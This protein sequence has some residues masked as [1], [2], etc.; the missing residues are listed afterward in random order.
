MTVNLRQLRAFHFVVRER[1]FSRAAA[2]ARTSQPTISMQ[3]AA[4]ERDHGVKLLERRGR[5]IQPTPLGNALYAVTTR[6]FA[7]EDEAR[8]LLGAP[9]APGH[10]HLR[11][12]ADNAF[13]AMPIL[14]AM[15]R[16][17]PGFTFSLAIGNSADAL[18]RLTNDEA[19]VAVSAQ[20]IADPRFTVVQL[21]RDRLVLFVPQR[22]AWRRRDRVHLAEL[23]GQPIV[24]RERGSVTR[25]TF[26]AA[27]AAARVTPGP[28]IEVETREA[29]RE[30]VAA[31]F[32]IGVVFQSEFGRDPRFR[33][34]AVADAKLSVGEYA[35][36][37]A[38]RRALALVAAFMTAAG[39]R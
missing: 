3:V 31:G 18:R 1:S 11:V 13:H 20:A 23:Q 2:A 22:H 25:E 15:R 26:E 24:L 38:S 28:V 16:Q 19:D 29:V 27:L 35:T 33:S 8:I 14:A 34:I 17:D 9:R 5:A 12:A 39:A 7:L 37:I 36:C 4:L 32:G 21:K 30:A 10:A 6:L